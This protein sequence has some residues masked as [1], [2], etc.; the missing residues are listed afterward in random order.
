MATKT[1]SVDDSAELPPELLTRPPMGKINLWRESSNTHVRCYI[2]LGGR[3]FERATTGVAIDASGSMQPEFGYGPFAR[4]KVREVA[5][6]M[7]PYIARTDTD[8]GT[9][10]IYWAT[11][12]PGEIQ[13]HGF[14][15]ESQAQ[16]YSYAPPKNYGRKTNLLP[17]LKYF[18]DGI[19]PKTGRP[20]RDYEMGIFI[21][22][23]DGAIEDME[24]V[25][26]YSTKLAQE[27]E[28]GKRKPI[29]LII[30]GV[31]TQIDE[32]QM[33]ELDDL[34]TGTSQDLY[35][36]RIAAQMTDLSD[37]FIELVNENMIIAQNGVVRDAKGAEVV[38]FRDTGVPALFEFN[39]PAGATS[40]TLEVEGQKFTQTLP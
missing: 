17:A 31:G 21:F 34:D 24:A 5:Q 14:L 3:T 13:P 28:A 32:Q 2:D 12:D 18:G 37:I 36:H 20:F 26:Q 29:K 11:G 4:N 8:G 6:V 22:V 38:N 39:L 7:C 15:A 40:F 27:I 10:L 1:Y 25:K 30:I 19:H 9:T 23:T 16:T 35:F 33:E